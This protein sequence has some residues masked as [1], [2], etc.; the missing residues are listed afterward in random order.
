MDAPSGTPL[1]EGRIGAAA[2]KLRELLRGL[3]L[4]VFDVDGVLTDGA[5]YL[6]P[7]EIELKRFAVEDGTAFMLLHALG[8]ETALVS[9]R[10][11]EPVL[12][13]ARELGVREVQQG[14]ADKEACLEALC[15]RRGIPMAQVFFQGDD[16]IDLPAIRR[17]GCGVAPANAA[18]EVRRAALFVTP[19]AGGHGAARDAVEWVLR[20]TGEYEAALAAYARGK[21]EPGRG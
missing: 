6:G 20:E 9:G 14:I 7:G 12:K 4:F 2:G 13:R 19:R 10:E 15:R 5:I 3:R 11:S 17:V 8:K 18:P 21:R 16:L 1:V